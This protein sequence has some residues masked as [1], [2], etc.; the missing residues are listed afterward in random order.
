[1]GDSASK[2]LK[3]YEQI[4]TGGSGKMGRNLNKDSSSWN[5]Q[6]NPAIRSM[7][8]ACSLLASC[9]SSSSGCPEDFKAYLAS[10]D[11]LYK[12]KKFEHNRFNVIFENAGAVVYH[13]DDIIDFLSKLSSMNMLGKSGNITEIPVRR[14]SGVDG[15]CFKSICNWWKCLFK[16]KICVAKVLLSTSFMKGVVIIFPIIARATSIRTACSLLA[17]GGSS[18]SG[19]PEDFKAYLA[20]KDKLYKLKKDKSLKT[21]FNVST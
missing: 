6:D 11:K 2:A 18:S 16:S 12:L 8:T 3:E 9:G 21:C 13:K 5:D 19:C 4:L 17:S 14:S 7:R 15:Q 20:S 10:K 1:M